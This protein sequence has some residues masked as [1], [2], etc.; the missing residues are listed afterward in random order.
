MHAGKIPSCAEGLSTLKDTDK[1]EAAPC[2]HLSTKLRNTSSTEPLPP[3]QPRVATPF[4]QMG[5]RRQSFLLTI[6][7][8]AC[9]RLF[10]R[11]G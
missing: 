4:S 11:G 6:Y 9:H 7:V 3:E 8:K 5:L 10:A 2:P 1:I